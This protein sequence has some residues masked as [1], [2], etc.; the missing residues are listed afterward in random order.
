[1][2]NKKLQDKEFKIQK[3][4]FEVKLEKVIRKTAEVYI[5]V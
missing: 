3:I 1:M 2:I 5:T 4:W